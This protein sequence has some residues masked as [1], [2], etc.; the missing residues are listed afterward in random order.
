M[1]KQPYWFPAKRYGWGWGL[2]NCWQG[3][4]VMAVY[5]LLVVTAVFSIR[6]EREPLLFFAALMVLTIALVAVCWIKGEPP[7]WRWGEK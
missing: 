7:R 3:W 6:P 4:A 2:P 1:Q 5:G